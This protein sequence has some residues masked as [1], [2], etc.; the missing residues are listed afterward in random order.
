MQF[1]DIRCGN[2]P[3]LV[4]IKPLVER[5]ICLYHGKLTLDVKMSNYK[6]DL[7]NYSKNCKQY[8][9]GFGYYYKEHLVI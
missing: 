4:E 1:F 6:L 9:I 3:R 7:C 8:L 5:L 2:Y